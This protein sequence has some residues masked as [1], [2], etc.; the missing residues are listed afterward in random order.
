MLT[1]TGTVVRMTARLTSLAVLIVSLAMT[2]F[3]ATKI[4]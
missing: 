4:W 2:A 3:F 1:R